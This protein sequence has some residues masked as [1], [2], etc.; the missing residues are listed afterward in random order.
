PAEHDAARLLLRW[1]ASL[2]PVSLLHASEV[3]GLLQAL[4]QRALDVSKQ[5]VDPSGH[6]WQP[7]SD[8]LVGSVLAALPW[9]GAELS[10]AC[11]AEWAALSGLVEAYLAAR[12]IQ[13]SEELRPFTAA[14][15]E[16]DMAAQ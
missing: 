5:G 13:F 3:A 2:P 16:G 1:L 4:V 10:V 11:P 12:P 6:S 15:R 14:T 7:W 9:A 8:W